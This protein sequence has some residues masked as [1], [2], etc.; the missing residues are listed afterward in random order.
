YLAVMQP[1]LQRY[2]IQLPDRQLACAPLNS[3]EGQQYVGAM[4]AAANYAWANRQ[5]MAHWAREAFAQVFRSDAR[6]LGMFQVY[7]VA[8][9]VCTFEEH[10]I[11]G[12]RRKVSV[13]RKG[14]TRSSP[15]GR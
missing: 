14:A 3:P 6:S 1:A 9:N 15:A 13:R 2:E 7:D 10:E 12:T 8:H 4:T 5:T 11:D